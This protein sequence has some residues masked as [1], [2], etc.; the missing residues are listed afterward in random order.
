M[1]DFAQLDFLV[2]KL[3]NLN[4]YLKFD[5][6]RYS[7]KPQLA[8]QYGQLIPGIVLGDGWNF[9]ISLNDYSIKNVVE[10]T[11]QINYVTY[12]T[13]ISEKIN[14]LLN[15]ENLFNK[16]DEYYRICSVSRDLLK[17]F[18]KYMTKIYNSE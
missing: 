3:I 14:S 6:N 9:S 18:T 4:F 1:N 5:D 11:H 2:K 13:E 10:S 12:L 7:S 8:N 17:D 15:N 16:T